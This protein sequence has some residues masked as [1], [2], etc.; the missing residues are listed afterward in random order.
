VPSLVVRAGARLC[1]LAVA[2]VV[3]TLRPLPVTPLRG[4]PACVRGV[5]VVRG[6]AVPVVDLAALLDGG[7]GRAATR[8][9]LLRCGTRTAALAVEAV[10]G[11]RSLDEAIAAV[12]PLLAEAGGGAVEKLGSLDGELLVV[13]R[14]AR[15]VPEEAWSAR[16]EREERR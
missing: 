10:V 14:A 3:E 6:Q 1:A 8:W 16:A 15:L 13:L 5:A 4:V 9:V 11:V 2:H 7:P 12:A